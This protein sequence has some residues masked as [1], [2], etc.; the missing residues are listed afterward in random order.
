MTPSVNVMLY[1]YICCCVYMRDVCMITVCH[2][3]FIE[4]QHAAV[5][6]CFSIE[7]IDV[8]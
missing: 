4:R 8:M 5:L 3:L 1:L 2:D 6:S 7:H